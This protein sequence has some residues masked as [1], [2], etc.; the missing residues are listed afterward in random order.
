M[1]QGMLFM[2]KGLL[3]MNPFHSDRKLMN[4][5]AVAGL[6][7]VLHSGLDMKSRMLL[8]VQS[9]R[10]MTCRAPKLTDQPEQKPMSSWWCGTDFNCTSHRQGYSL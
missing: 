3:T 1:A 2:G 7:I 10:N 9:I 4:H 6:L 8:G 5:T